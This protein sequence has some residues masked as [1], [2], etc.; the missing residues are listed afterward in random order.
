[1]SSA[2]RVLKTAVESMEAAR[3]ATT[4]PLKELREWRL[5]ASRRFLGVIVE[6]SKPK[7]KK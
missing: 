3:G 5:S 1:M 4:D 2:R 6:A 7:G